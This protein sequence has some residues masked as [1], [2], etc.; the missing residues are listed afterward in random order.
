MAVVGVECDNA[1]QNCGGDLIKKN[2]RVVD[3]VCVFL[4][5]VYPRA[6]RGARLPVAVGI[7]S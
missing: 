2:E 5:D 3:D 7:I 6:V 4:F 1:E